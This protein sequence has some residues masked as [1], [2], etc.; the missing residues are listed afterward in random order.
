ME[1]RDLNRKKLLDLKNFEANKL[2]RESSQEVVLETSIDELYMKDNN[3]RA[4]K[5]FQD[6]VTVYNLNDEETESQRSRKRTPNPWDIY[7]RRQSLK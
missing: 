3:P 1:I 4:S 6:I 2:A 7:Q 5:N